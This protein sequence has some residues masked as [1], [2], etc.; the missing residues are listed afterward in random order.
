MAELEEDVKQVIQEFVSTAVAGAVKDMGLDKIDQKYLIV[1]AE[2]ANGM[3]EKEQLKQKKEEALGKMAKALWAKNFALAEQQ[4]AI[5]KTADPNNMTTDADGAYLVPDETDADIIGLIPSYGQARSL[6]SVG[7]FPINRDNLVVPKRGDGV[8]VYYPG[9][10]A[11][12]TSSKLSLS[13]VTMVAKK[14]AAIAVLTDEL[15]DFAIVDFV[16][17][18]KER[19]AEG[20]GKDEDS[21]I[22]GVGNTTFTG[23]FYP[24]NS[25][26]DS[27]NADPDAITYDNIM[28]M[29]YAVD[30]KYLQG[31]RFICHR[32]LVPSLRKIK[33]DVGNP[34]FV[35]PNSAANVQSLAGYPLTII[36]QSTAKDSLVAGDPF[37][38]LGNMKNSMIKDKKGMRIDQSTEAVVDSSSLFQLDLTALRFIRHWSFHSGLVEAYVALKK[39]GV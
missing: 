11:S 23:L 15:K 20:F 18:I 37:L 22:F 12:I 31:A 8:T 16:A 24:S 33:D 26:G 39:A 19:A 1:P 5:I 13:T 7:N 25:Y 10:A 17:Y 21:K 29:L 27:I 14:A 38:L 2:N 4:N 3:T 9:E 32:T 34:L 30:Q 6:V 28:D 35:Q 36:E